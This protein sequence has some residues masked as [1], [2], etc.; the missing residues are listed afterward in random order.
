VTSAPATSVAAR[1]ATSAPAPR[2]DQCFCLS[3]PRHLEA[4]QV[5]LDEWASQ[6]RVRA[7]LPPLV[8]EHDRAAIDEAAGMLGLG[9]DERRAFQAAA[10]DTS[11]AALARVRD[12]YTTATGDAAGTI[13]VEDLL[14]QIDATRTLGED[15]HVRATLS[16]ERAGRT[17]PQLDPG[18]MTPYE[19]LYRL[20]ITAGD[21]FERRL[22][23]RL[24]AA[25]ARELRLRF[26]GWP[27]P[28]FDWIGCPAP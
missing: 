1:P 7:D 23:D 27:G 28:D 8:D 25:R 10:E 6:C 18:R 17:P 5:L 13:A 19:E 15:A 21:D 22:A 3:D 16:R 12:I 24:G 20:L 4:D 2:G 14:E 26:G 9:G 11:R